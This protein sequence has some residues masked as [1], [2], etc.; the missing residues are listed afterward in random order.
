MKRPFFEAYLENLKEQARLE[1]SKAV[2]KIVA[3]PEFNLAYLKTRKL[4]T[5]EEEHPKLIKLK[6]LV[7]KEFKKNTKIKMIVFA[8]FRDTVTK[9]SREL[10]AITGV[11]ARVFV[12]Q[13]IKKG[14]VQVV[15][16]TNKVMI[17]KNFVIRKYRNAFF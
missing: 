16:R 13:A 5:N 1:K 12:G 17:L 4:L 7:E 14:K 2:Q 9:I 6:E 11:N 3:K 15:S 10:N 8:Q